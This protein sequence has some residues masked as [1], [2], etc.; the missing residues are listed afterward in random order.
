MS[1]DSISHRSLKFNLLIYPLNFRLITLSIPIYFLNFFRI[2]NLPALYWKNLTTLF[3]LILIYDLYK[4]VW[5]CKYLK[6]L[7]L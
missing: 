6:S 2:I 7:R 4:K 5:L 3:I 1:I